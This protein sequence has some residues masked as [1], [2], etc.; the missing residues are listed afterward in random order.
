MPLW[1]RVETGTCC[2]YTYRLN[3]LA[4]YLLA[5]GWKIEIVVMPRGR[6]E[7]VERR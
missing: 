4:L 5:C 3:P 6:A 2:E 7:A 1:E